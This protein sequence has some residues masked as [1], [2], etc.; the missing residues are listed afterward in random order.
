[1]GHIKLQ[2]YFPPSEARIILRTSLDWNL[3]LEPVLVSEDR[4]CWE[5][6]V[7][8]EQH[9]FYFKPCLVTDA[10]VLWSRGENYLGTTTAEDET[11][12]LYPIFHSEH[13]GTFS[14][15]LSIRSASGAIT[16]RFRV[17]FPPGYDENTLKRYPVLY[18]HDGS[19]LFFADEAFGGNEWQVDENLEA[20]DNMNLIDKV[21]VV[22]IYAL[23][24][25][26]EY[27]QPGYEQYGR[28][29]VEEL[30]PKIDRELRTLSDPSHTAVMGSSLGG[31]VSFYLGWQYPEVFGKAGCLSSTFGYKDDLMERVAR[32]PKR[33][34]R[35]YIDSGWPEDNYENTTA[36]RDQLLAA[37]YE[38]GRELSYYAFPGAHHTESAW[39]ARSHIPFQWFF[40]KMARLQ[41]ALKAV[42]QVR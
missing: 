23:D 18:M 3:D 10:E 12:Q 21:I 30:K 42:R 17:Y 2:V 14:D 33:S 8:T 1:M 34:T 40:G 20:L 7:E 29:V 4:S 36:M 13:Q 26:A 11:R 24:R 9:Y 37:G 38:F 28:L 25:M 22:G 32:E 5:F 41:E 35:F 39:A 19:N 6:R 16:H 27:T 15:K 31:V